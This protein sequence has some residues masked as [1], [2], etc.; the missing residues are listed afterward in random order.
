M[1]TLFED[2]LEPKDGCNGCNSFAHFVGFTH[3]AVWD[4]S[5]FHSAPPR[6]GDL[7]QYTYHELAYFIGCD[8]PHYPVPAIRTDVEIFPDRVIYWSMERV[9][10][11]EYLAIS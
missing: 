3:D 1:V 2:D 9:W 6:T 8:Q 7:C 5:A 11:M 10:R 4:C